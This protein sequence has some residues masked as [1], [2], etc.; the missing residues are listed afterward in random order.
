[1]SLFILPEYVLDE[2]NRFINENY[3]YKLPYSII[4]ANAFCCKFKCYEIE[5]G[6]AAIT[7]AIENGKMH[8]LF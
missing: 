4:I 1:M 6:V 3:R 7:D 8:C 2:L 5:F